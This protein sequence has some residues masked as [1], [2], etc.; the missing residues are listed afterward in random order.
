M[1]Q[2]SKVFLVLAAIITIFA[3]LSSFYSW[4]EN[5]EIEIMLCGYF[6]YS[7]YVYF[8]LMLTLAALLNFVKYF[9]KYHNETMS[10]I[11]ATAAM[12][13]I[14]IVMCVAVYNHMIQKLFI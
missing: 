9:K 5:K 1:K 7:M 13:F 4:D 10:V 12:F 6:Y 2:F 8:P 11:F 3:V 14:S